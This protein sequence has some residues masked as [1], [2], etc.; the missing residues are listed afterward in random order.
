[1]F[2]AE[3]VL[4]EDHIV[5]AYNKAK[6]CFKNDSN[7]AHSLEIETLLW[8]SGERQIKEALSKMG[9][10][11]DSENAVLAIEN[12]IVG[13][14]NHMGWKRKDELLTPSKEKLKRF[15][16]TEKEMN[17]VEDPYELIFEKMATSIL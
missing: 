3:L 16:I 14:L 1:M 12:D 2:N 9:L 17:S 6:Q 4:N 15:G 5:W 11:E 7:R 8:A 10:Q 13:F